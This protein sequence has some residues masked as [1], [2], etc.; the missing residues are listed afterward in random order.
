MKSKSRLHCIGKIAYLNSRKEYGR[1]TIHFSRKKCRF[2]NFRNL[3]LFTAEKSAIL[4]VFQLMRENGRLKSNIL[5][6]WKSIFFEKKI[7][8]FLIPP[9]PPSLSDETTIKSVKM[10]FLGIY[11]RKSSWNCIYETHKIPG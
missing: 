7:I 4:L 10:Y 5:M 9:P 2:L 1:S 11:V 6:P 3:S 8:S